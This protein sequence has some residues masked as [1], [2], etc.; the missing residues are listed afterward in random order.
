MKSKKEVKKDR[1]GIGG[2]PSKYRESMLPKII[3]LMKVG[4]SK[5]EVCALLE[6]DDNTLYDWCSKDSPR[7]KK[8]FSETIKRGVELS[9]AWWL[10]MG[11]TNLSDPKFSYTGWY[12]NMKNRFKWADKQENKTELSLEKSFG[13]LLGLLPKDAIKKLKN[14]VLDKID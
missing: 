9:K 11:R 13:K 7:F 10:K 5:T 8:E 14:K 3:E 2:R 6:I 1:K 4:G 12:M